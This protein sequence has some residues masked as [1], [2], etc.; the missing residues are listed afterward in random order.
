LG[1]I[2]TW[3]Y[4]PSRLFDFDIKFDKNGGDGKYSQVAISPEDPG[5]TRSPGLQIIAGAPSQVLLTYLYSE[6]EMP[7]KAFLFASL[8]FALP[9]AWAQTHENCIKKA[10]ALGNQVVGTPDLKAK[11]YYDQILALLPDPGAYNDLANHIRELEV[12]K[13]QLHDQ[14]A[15]THDSSVAQQ[16]QNTEVE[17]SQKQQ[18]AGTMLTALMGGKFEAFKK[19][20]DDA[21]SHGIKVDSLADGSFSFQYRLDSESGVF[22]DRTVTFVPGGM[23]NGEMR[24]T[25]DPTGNQDWRSDSLFFASYAPECAGDR[26]TQ[27]HLNAQDIA[28]AVK[29]V[30]AR[31]PTATGTASGSTN[32]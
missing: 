30:I 5:S 25:K 1:E 26:Q 8:T 17:E 14:Y 22:V 18:Q 7:L 19:I 15:K 11:Q 3:L 16:Q 23:K 4:G 12:K 20:T 31:Q 32:R 29:K 21:K 24:A 2:A 28:S 13:N 10:E 27:A 6:V 9:S